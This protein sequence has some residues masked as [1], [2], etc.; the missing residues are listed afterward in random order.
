MERG[1]GGQAYPG[2]GG[3]YFDQ[4]QEGPMSKFRLERQH[5]LLKQQTNY[6]D[7]EDSDEAA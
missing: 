3:A 6:H 4:Y 5:Q 1:Q 2:R 7:D